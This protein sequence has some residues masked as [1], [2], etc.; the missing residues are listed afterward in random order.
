[1]P[2]FLL[3]LFCGIVSGFGTYLYSGDNTLGFLVGVVV[4]VFTWCGVAVVVIADD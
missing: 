4:T 2:A 1:M 3:G